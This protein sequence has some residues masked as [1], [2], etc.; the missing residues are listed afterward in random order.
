MQV[1]NPLS[2]VLWSRYNTKAKEKR[3][4]IINSCI[5]ITT[6]LMDWGCSEMPI[7]AA[8]IS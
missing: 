1:D 7:A 8:P 4:A 6:V 2:V 5:I 3:E